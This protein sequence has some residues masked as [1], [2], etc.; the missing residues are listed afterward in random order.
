MSYAV[1]DTTVESGVRGRTGV[2]SLG[3]GPTNV[4]IG[5][6]GQWQVSTGSQATGAS[7]WDS[8]TQWSSQQ[9]VFAGVPNILVLA[10][11]FFGLMLLRGGGRRR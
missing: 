10:G 6:G 5:P 11:G 7:I 3:I 8:I 4:Y 2:G 9:T 1:T